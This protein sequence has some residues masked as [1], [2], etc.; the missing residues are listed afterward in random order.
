MKNNCSHP[1]QHKRDTSDSEQNAILC[2]RMTFSHLLM[3]PVVVGVSKFDYACLI[4]LDTG[5]EMNEICCCSLLPPQQLL[6]PHW[7]FQ[8]QERAL[9]YSVGHASFLILIFHKVVQQCV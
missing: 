3:V 6:V 9:V 4:L 5:V 1:W 2:T 7:Q 8:F